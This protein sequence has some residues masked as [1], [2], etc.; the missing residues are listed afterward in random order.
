MSQHIANRDSLDDLERE[1]V[2]EVSVEEP[3]ALLEEFADLTRVSGTE[4]EVVAAEYITD[5]LDEFGVR[6]E[7]YDPKLYISQPHEASVRALDREFE[8]GPVK[9]ISFSAAATVRGKSSTWARRGR[10]CS[11]RSPMS[12]NRITTSATSPERSR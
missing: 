12:G 4:D 11:T 2:D 10:T 3:W 7:R 5:R 6:Y 1:V 8:S 9:T